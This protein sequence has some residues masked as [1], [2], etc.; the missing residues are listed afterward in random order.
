MGWLSSMMSRLAEEH[1][2]APPDG[3]GWVRATDGGRTTSMQRLYRCPECNGVWAN[4][5]TLTVSEPQQTVAL[6]AVG[7][8]TQ[9]A[10]P[11]GIPSGAAPTGS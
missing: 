1:H 9:P 3:P 6:K 8:A 10:R 11:E 7:G 2:C 5:T 4:P